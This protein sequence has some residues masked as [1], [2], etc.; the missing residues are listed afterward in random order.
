[1]P[2]QNRR[3]FGDDIS[4][5]LSCREIYEFRLNC[6]A[7]FPKGPIYYFSAL[8]QKMA[9]CRSSDKPISEPMLVRLPTLIRITRPQWVKAF[10][11]AWSISDH[12]GWH[13]STIVEDISLY[14]QRDMSI[15]RELFEYTT[16]TVW[17]ILSMSP[18][19]ISINI[20]SVVHQ[21]PTFSYWRLSVCHNITNAYIDC[22]RYPTY[23]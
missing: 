5:T 3:H 6:T 9:W 19:C 4:N 2:A 22:C 14:C 16:N 12:H 13:L 15:W 23:C 8:V 11:V 1:M 7:F 21:L 20:C 17:L 18:Y 10:K